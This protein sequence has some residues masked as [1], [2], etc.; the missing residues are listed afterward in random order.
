MAEVETA[1]QLVTWEIW[2]LNLTDLPGGR[3]WPFFQVFHVLFELHTCKY[4]VPT[5]PKLGAILM[6]EVGPQ[7]T[8]TTGRTASWDEPQS[9]NS[10]LDFS[11]KGHRATAAV[12]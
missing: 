3:L 2:G 11:L 4:Q 10:W 8:S 1:T 5:V 9:C 6:E 12:L 7:N